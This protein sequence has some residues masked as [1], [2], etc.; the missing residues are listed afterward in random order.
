MEV[1]EKVRR[2]EKVAIMFSPDMKDR[3]DKIAVA[4]GMP[5]STLC[6]FAVASWV[7]SQENQLAMARMA[8]MQMARQAGDKIEDLDLEKVLQPM[9]VEMAKQQGDPQ[10]LLPLDR[11]ASKD[12]E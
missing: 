1:K 10:A 11:E 6:S 2:V 5:P 8:V 3:I 4:F 7:Q 9:I 12:A